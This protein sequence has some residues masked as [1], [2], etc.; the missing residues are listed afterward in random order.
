[1]KKFFG[2]VLTGVLLVVLAMVLGMVGLFHWVGRQAE[3]AIADKSVLVFDLKGLLP[4][5]QIEPASADLFA[6]LSL[7]TVLHALD[8]AAR[9]PRIVGMLIEG[10]PRLPR[11]YLEELKVAVDGFRAEGKPVLA[12]LELGFDGS[13]GLAC[14]ADRIALSPSV[15]GGLFLAGPSVESLY[16]RAGLEKLG[17]ELRVLH[18]GEAKGFGEKYAADRMSPAVRENLG[19]LVED[20]FDEQLR[21]IAE[22]R[23]VE[24]ETLRRVL[25]E[26]GRLSIAPREALELGLVDQV[27]SRAAWVEAVHEQFDEAPRLSLSRWIRSRPQWPSRLEPEGAA[28]GEHLAVVWAEGGIVPG[29]GEGGGVEI[30]SRRFV[31]LLEKLR[32]DEQTLAVL[33]RIESG[34]GSALASDEICRELQRLAERKPLHVSIGPVAASGGYYIAAPARRIWASPGSVTGS[35]GVVAL[36]PDLSSAAGKLG[37]TPQGIQ[38]TALA[39]LAAPGNPLEE[40]TVAGLSAQLDKIYAEFTGRVLEHRPIARDELAAIAGGR[41]WSGRRALDL[42]LVDTLGT[43]SEAV[44]ALR[45]ELER[46]DLRLRHL[47]RVRSLVEQLLEG[48]LKPGDLLPGLAGADLQDLDPTLGELLHSRTDGDAASAAWSGLRAEWGWRLRE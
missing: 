18:V 3:P 10:S 35:I 33:L 25:L 17:V 1:M 30:S 43:L 34:G 26:P 24:R 16:M 14:L 38:P 11:Q 13:Y 19:L 22:H 37:L 39:R 28:G 21:W 5:H 41:V 48:E 6:P 29:A 47:P 23:G 45:H 4:G 40:A 42:G 31:T 12:H 7:S 46:P 15:S 9:D 32:E 20:L 8:E 36:L 27:A 44:D 2:G